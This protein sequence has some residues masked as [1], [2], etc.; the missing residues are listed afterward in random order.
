MYIYLFVYLFICIYVFSVS[1]KSMDPAPYY[2]N[3]PVLNHDFLVAPSYEA[4]KSSLPEKLCV[5]MS[6]KERRTW[7]LKKGSS[8]GHHNLESH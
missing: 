2:N 3:L 4:P 6:G 7:I 8:K 1:P 5:N